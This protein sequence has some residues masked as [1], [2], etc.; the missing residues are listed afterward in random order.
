VNS[1]P[2]SSVLLSVREAD[3]VYRMGEVDVHALRGASLDIYDGEFLIIVG[4][5]GSGKTTL[6]NLIGGMDRPTSGRVLFDGRDLSRASDRALT[7]Y[8]RR[9]VGFVFQFYN[10]VPTLTALENVQV[11]CELADDP[12][13]PLEALR[14]VH[15]EDRADHFPAQLSGGEQQ[16]VAIARALAGRPR[17]L[18][19]DE[20]TGSLDLEASREV[21][22]MLVG[23]NRDLKKTIVLITHN[24]AIARIGHRIAHIRD[25]AISAVEANAAPCPVEEVTW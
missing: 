11:A 7:R 21:L 22:G 6:L 18:L 4:P 5:S 2:A 10:L 17:L 1:A 15:L 14:L 9:E 20:P 12:L 24:G 3:K 25:G 8:R 19:C 16:R 13:D 23:L